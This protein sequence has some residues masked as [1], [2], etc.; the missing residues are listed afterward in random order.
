M[1]LSPMLISSA[2]V[3]LSL[4]GTVSA[5]EAA[6]FRMQL[7]APMLV[8]GEAGEPSLPELGTLSLSAPSGT[9]TGG[10][11][12]A[13]TVTYSGPAALDGFSHA[14]GAGLDFSR[15]GDT[16]RISGSLPASGVLEFEVS[17]TDIHGRAVP[18]VTVYNIVAPDD[19]TTTSVV[20]TVCQDGTIYAG[21][22]NGFHRF[23]V[24]PERE[25]GLYKAAE[26][27]DLVHPATNA[28]NGK[29]N[30]DAL[31]AFPGRYPA[32]A[33]CRAKG[34]DWYLPSANEIHYNLAGNKARLPGGFPWVGEY[35]R[36]WSSTS[37]SDGRFNTVNP[38]AL[39]T[40]V[41]QGVENL[42]R[43]AKAK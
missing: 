27:P 15:D 25:P 37:Q 12:Y 39:G 29:S 21:D 14:G 9:L 10:G 26:G 3:A 5:D 24:A 33:A 19:C 6:R 32:A 22:T 17:A 43:C 18:A 1:R 35:S 38:N 8:G 11:A 28:I 31:M 36:Y 23:Y 30:T 41:G 13:A 2:L 34:P 42:V 7:Q 4:A 20:G 40:Q 16:Y